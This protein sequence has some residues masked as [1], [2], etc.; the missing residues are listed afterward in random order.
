MFPLSCACVCEHTKKLNVAS[1]NVFA[2]I[3]YM[4][5]QIQ[6]RPGKT[7]HKRNFMHTQT[8]RKGIFVKW[9]VFVMVFT[10]LI[11]HSP[12]CMSIPDFLGHHDMDMQRWMHP[13]NPDRCFPGGSH[14]F[15]LASISKCKTMPIVI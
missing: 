7:L 14:P 4:L 11:D 10:C 15:D 8:L 1:K 12:L 2:H 13:D 5:L 9:S 3:S 6:M